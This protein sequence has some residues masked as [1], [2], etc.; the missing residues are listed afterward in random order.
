[1]T[2]KMKFNTSL[3]HGN[4]E[5]KKDTGATLTPIYQSSAFE[6]ESAERLEKVF[7]NAAPGFAYTRISNPTIA[8]FEKRITLLEGGVS[9][10]ACASGM[11]AIFNAIMNVVRSGDE[12]ISNTGIFGGTI[13]LFKDLESFGINTK[14]I[15]ETTVTEIEKKVS[16]RTKIIFAETIGNPKLDILDIQAVAKFAK[17]KNIL[18]I[19]D[20]TVATAYLVKPIELGADIVINSS[21]KYING[22]G[23]SISGVIIDSGKFTWSEERYPSIKPYKKMGPFAFTAKIRETLFRNTGACLSPFNA[24]LNSVGLETMGIRMERSCDN[25]YK[26]AKYFETNEKI[27][28]VNYPGLE[29]NPYHNIAKK[30]FKNGFGAMVTIRVGSKEKAFSIINNLKYSLKV[31]NI[32]DTKTLV[33]HPASTIY[34]HS[35]EEEK[36][37]AGVYEDLIRIS[38]G[39]EDIEDLIA[40]F[41]QAIDA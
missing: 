9:T 25:A 33:I 10:V 26:L 7:L 16:D 11:A 28:S 36:K 31:S 29:S 34:I 27:H 40:D 3:L 38:V 17:E 20:N 19:V 13:G 41:K 6:Q 22:S 4:I 18:F 2:S 35:T 24:Y 30:Q 15:K 8:S 32:G 12:I 21:S 5:S 1:M 14:Y 39:I 37:N 23:N